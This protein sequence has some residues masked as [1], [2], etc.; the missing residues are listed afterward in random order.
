M[1]DVG[2]E[3]ERYMRGEGGEGISDHLL[4]R[5]WLEA[6]GSYEDVSESAYNWVCPHEETSLRD[7]VKGDAEDV[8]QTQTL[9]SEV[10][11]EVSQEGP[12]GEGGY[13]SERLARD[14][15]RS[16]KTLDEVYESLKGF[17]PG[18]LEE[19]QECATRLVYRDGQES[20]EVLVIGE[21]PGRDEDRE[22]LPFV[23]RSGQ[24]LD[25]VLGSV[26]LSRTRNVLLTNVVYWRPPGNR[27]PTRSE[28][29]ACRPFV[30]KTI[31]IARPHVIVL[32]GAVPAGSVLRTQEAVGSLR[33]KWRSYGCEVSGRE[34][35]VLVTFHPSYLLRSPRMKGH[36][37]R[38]VVTLRKRLDEKGLRSGESRDE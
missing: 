11:R 16:C 32:T 37:W 31:E 34:H 7:A 18:V 29:M 33:G 5:E 8:G 14:A 27:N 26:G 22:G 24:L 12:H 38:D 36:A 9:P 6:M 13:D 2:L 25:K 19:L 21:A 4:W 10:P 35:D 23:G 28:V 15:V 30:E 3:R 17:S 1:T 20:P